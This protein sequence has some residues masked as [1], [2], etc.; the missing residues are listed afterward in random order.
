MV[1]IE[2]GGIE[3]AL[4]FYEKNATPH[5]VIL[6]TNAV[7]EPLMQEVESLAEV[8]DA[9]TSVLLVGEANDIALYRELLSRGISEY[10]VR[11]FAPKQMF[12]AIA[13]IFIDPDAPPMGR[14]VAFT[15][16]RGGAGSST[17]SHNVAWMLGSEY[18]ED[19]V[20]VDLDLA[21]GTAALSF[22][23]EV[24]QGVHTALGDIER[25]DD[26][27]LDRFLM[28]YGENLRVLG[29][30][31]SLDFDERIPI[32]AIDRL[33]DLTR[34]RASYVILDL[35]H[36]WAPWTRQLLLDSD[37]SVVTALL[38]LAS[39]RDTKN[40][41]DRLIS[42]RGE[43][44]PVYVALNH[45]G[46]YKRTELTA[47]DFENA[48]EIEPALVI[49]HDPNLFGEAANNG[50]MLAEVNR[51]HKV[52]ENFRSFVQ[53]VTGRQAGPGPMKKK[54]YTL[55]GKSK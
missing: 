14:M 54:K 32:E 7:K 15:G 10:M 12:D 48:I 33:L 42:Q 39:L 2:S 25:L 40:V 31:A 50:Q 19:V 4:S 8:C 26:V 1:D 35:P 24:G 17:V 44:A 18:N 16:S 49:P 21:F 3:A 6:E 37:V 52:V 47:K 29:A 30:P 46:A 43:G 23:L 55:F 28:P 11:P 34:R 27:L 13:S 51:K 20:V 9:G 41:V 53:T 36:M 22:N 38:D 45:E 5:L